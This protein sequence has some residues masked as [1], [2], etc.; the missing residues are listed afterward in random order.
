MIN[1]EHR[2]SRVILENNDLVIKIGDMVRH[3]KFGN[4]KIMH[5]QIEGKKTT[6]EVFF[7]GLGKKVLDLNIA[8]IEKV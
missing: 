6:A 3:A 7:I 1:P 5:L 2:T 4:G 8:K